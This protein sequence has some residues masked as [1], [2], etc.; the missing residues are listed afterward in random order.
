MKLQKYVRKGKGYSL[1]VLK[2]VI[3]VRKKEKPVRIDFDG[4]LININSLRL[5]MFKNKGV[6]CYSC[7]IEGEIIHKEKSSING[8][9]YHF[10]LYAYNSNGHE[11]LMTKDHIIPKSKGGEDHIR[12]LET[13]CS[14]CNR[15]KDNKLLKDMVK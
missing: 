9:I 3:D 6:K 12:N 1:E 8:K 10:N 5:S 14:P 13:M 15:T 7:G 2:Y 4:D 11:V